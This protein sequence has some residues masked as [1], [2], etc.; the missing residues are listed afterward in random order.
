LKSALIRDGTTVARHHATIHSADQIT[1]A[2]D[3][4]I[5]TILDGQAPDVVAHRVVHGGEAFVA[6]VIADDAVVEQLGTLVDLAPLHQPAALVGIARARDRLPDI[7][8]VA[9][10][11]TAFH[12]DL[13]EVAR[14]LPLPNWCWDAGIRRY[15][16]HGLSYEYLVGALGD[17][18]GP[19]AV[20]AHL[21]SG[22]SL[23]ALA[24]GTPV[25]TSMSLT[26]GG[27][28][29]M[30]TRSGD[31]DPGVVLALLRRPDAQIHGVEELLEHESGIR[32]LSDGTGDFEDLL[33]VADQDARAALALQAFAR[34]V[35]KEIAGAVAVLGGLDTLVFSGGI[36]ANSPWARAAVVENLAH[37]GV[38]L[39]QA[40]NLTGASVISTAGSTVIVHKVETDEE[41]ILARHALRV[42]REHGRPDGSG[43]LEP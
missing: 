38:H 31:L 34:S 16:F 36:G 22:S 11:D 17:A 19:R 9:C 39:D 7:P 23:V 4:V 42:V 5:D 18:L 35:S 20:L 14:R 24:D 8:S 15:G 40:A 6:P 13:P 25:D 12:H 3:A 1:S 21:G 28:L 41:L 32:G 43:E 26:P 27:G 10:F 33:A 2:V 37:L 30:A 29:L